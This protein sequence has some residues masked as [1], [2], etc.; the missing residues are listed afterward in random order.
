MADLFKE[1]IPSILKTKKPAFTD[2]P[3]YKTYIPFIIN[4]AL[5][6]HRDCILYANEMNKHHQLDK[7]IQYAYLLNTI[8]SQYRP[9]QKWYKNEPQTEDFKTVKEFF[10]VS[11][12]KAV[13]ILKLLTSE[14]ID[15]IRKKIGGLY[16]TARGPGRDNSS[17]SR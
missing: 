17:K 11:N 7:D 6:L 1:I 4:K 16:D 9:R 14:Q 2:D 15:D 12:E 8:R 10:K 5:S 13:D 3:E